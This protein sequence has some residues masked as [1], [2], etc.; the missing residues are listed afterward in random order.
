M[1]SALRKRL[2]KALV[3]EVMAKT[4]RLSGSTPLELG[5]LMADFGYL[6]FDLD[7]QPTMIRADDARNLVFLPT[8]A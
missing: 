1:A 7:L 3:V 2:F 6:P 5:A 8:G 4:L